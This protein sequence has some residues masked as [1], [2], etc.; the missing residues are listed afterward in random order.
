MSESSNNHPLCDVYPDGVPILQ[1]CLHFFFNWIQT[2]AACTLWTLP[3]P[4]GLH[5]NE[6]SSTVT[7]KM[8]SRWCLKSQDP[9]F[10]LHL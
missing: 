9:V 4:S 7:N 2:L 3:M 6:V 8:V 10:E 5:C 1:D